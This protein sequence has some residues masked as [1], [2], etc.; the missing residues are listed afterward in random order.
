MKKFEYKILDIHQGPEF[1]NFHMPEYELN[2]LGK[3]GWEAVLKIRK[4][5]HDDPIERNWP[6][7]TFLFKRELEV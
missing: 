2:E 1:E 3:E 6:I 4:W 7:Y 5:Y